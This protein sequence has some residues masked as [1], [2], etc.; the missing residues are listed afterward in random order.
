[1]NEGDLRC[2]SGHSIA[3]RLGV[4]LILILPGVAAT[5][6]QGATINQKDDVKELRLAHRRTEKTFDGRGTS[7]SGREH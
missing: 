2:L 1:M 6:D 4:C 3:H 7:A 5:G